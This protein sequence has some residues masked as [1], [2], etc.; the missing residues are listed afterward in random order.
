MM[1]ITGLRIKICV[2]FGSVKDPINGKIIPETPEPTEQVNSPP[3]EEVRKP[4]VLH[5]V[6]TNSPDNTSLC[7]NPSYNT[8]VVHSP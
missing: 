3:L 7:A 8:S 4:L 1:T 6:H 2:W 5:S